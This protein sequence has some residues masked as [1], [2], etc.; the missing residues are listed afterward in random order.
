ML[1]EEAQTHIVLNTFEYSILE[2]VEPHELIKKMGEFKQDLKT[3]V[4]NYIKYQS[5]AFEIMLKAGW[6]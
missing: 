6:K 4:K 2:N 5:D 1:T 3:P